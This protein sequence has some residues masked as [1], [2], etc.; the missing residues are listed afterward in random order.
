MVT[1]SVYRLYNSIH[2]DDDDKIE[3]I[4]LNS[5]ESLA[6]VQTMSSDSTFSR[7]G[8]PGTASSVER[9]PERSET[10]RIRK[11]FPETWIWANLTSG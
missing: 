1:T 7:E 11:K 5:A 9:R 2:I 3:D 8:S 10:I 4:S 6:F